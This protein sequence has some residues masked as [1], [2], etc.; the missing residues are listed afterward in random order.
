MSLRAIPSMKLQE[1]QDDGTI[2]S[3]RASRRQKQPALKDHDFYKTIG[4]GEA[5]PEHIR[6]LQDRLKAIT[7]PP[8]PKQLPK[9]DT[10]GHHDEEGSVAHRQREKAKELS[11]PRR[12]SLEMANRV[13]LRKQRMR[14]HLRNGG[15]LKELEAEYTANF[16]KSTSPAPPSKP[17][18]GSKK[19]R[20]K[21]RPSVPPGFFTMEPVQEDVDD[22]EDEQ[23]RYW[24]GRKPP[25]TPFTI[26]PSPATRSGD[27][28]P[29]GVSPHV[30]WRRR[31]QKFRQ[32]KQAELDTLAQDHHYRS[33][34]GSPQPQRSRTK[35]SPGRRKSPHRPAFGATACPAA[36]EPR[37]SRSSLPPP[38]SAQ[39]GSA[40]A[41][42]KAQPMPP[43]HLP[44]HPAF[45]RWKVTDPEQI[46]NIVVHQVEALSVLIRTTFEALDWR[47]GVLGPQQFNLFVDHVSRQLGLPP[48]GPAANRLAFR[49]WNAP[50]NV[51]VPGKVSYDQ[52]RA[53]V[54]GTLEFERQV[55][56]NGGYDDDDEPL[57]ALSRKEPALVLEGDFPRVVSERGAN[58]VD[59]DPQDTD[60]EDYSEDEANFDQAVSA[61]E[62]PPTDEDA[63]GSD[64][65]SSKSHSC[66]SEHEEEDAS[67]SASDA[68]DGSYTSDAADETDG[69][70]DESADEGG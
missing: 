20:R 59:T 7:G 69:G 41:A 14:E 21:P 49:F 2:L 42:A 55:L 52:A 53:E 6:A 27:A 54:K 36:Q 64:S 51:A 30:R 57:L 40:D 24:L 18:K 22:V 45:Q 70:A 39:G 34:R 44:T 26:P 28:S 50:A 3:T 11:R 68:S 15:T 29:P 23:L 33:P 66:H 17:P 8:W 63:A 5:T 16:P 65:D 12:L 13:I 9:A 4:N 37:A 1:A 48:P 43:T 10:Y 46:S 25:P 38:A 61:E 58:D 35:G 60:Q 19:P 47:T 67:A 56:E 31:L 62:A 32:E